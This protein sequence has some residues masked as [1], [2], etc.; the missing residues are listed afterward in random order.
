MIAELLKFAK[1]LAALER[2]VDG[3]LRLAVVES[4]DPAAGTAVLSAGDGFSS[5]PVPYAQSGGP[6]KGHVPPGEGQQMLLLSPGG[7]LRSGV[8]IPAG[9]GGSHASPGDNA[10]ANVFTFGG[11]R[12]EVKGDALVARVGGGT[13]TITGSEITLDG[14]SLTINGPAVTH[15]GT[16]IGKDHVHG[17]VLPGGALTNTPQ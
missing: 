6:F 2:R 9:F 11:V 4:V 7:D 12:M 3:L 1:R 14:L 15:G 5:P 8:A 10:E 17:G 16:N 13:V